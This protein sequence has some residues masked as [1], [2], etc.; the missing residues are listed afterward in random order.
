MQLKKIKTKFDLKSLFSFGVGLSL[1]YLYIFQFSW[2]IYFSIMKNMW[3]V[4]YN[5][6]S[7]KSLFFQYI[8]TGDVWQYRFS[9]NLLYFN[10]WPCN[11]SF[12]FGEILNYIFVSLW[13]L[14]NF[15]G[16][17]PKFSKLRFQFFLFPIDSTE[18]IFFMYLFFFYFI[19]F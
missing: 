4:Q 10:D 6:W 12:A 1:L 18:F 16:H 8:F 2:W 3:I 17:S 19:F 9:L 7:N 5:N 11:I 15:S 13:N 14:S